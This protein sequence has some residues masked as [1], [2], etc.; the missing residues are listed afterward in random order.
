MVR[1]V[2]L[3]DKATIHFIGAW[4][5]PLVQKLAL[6]QVRTGSTSDSSA[7]ES[8]PSLASFKF[9]ANLT[10]NVREQVNW[11]PCTHSWRVSMKRGA[12]TEDN[13][14]TTA[15]YP[16]LK[17]SEYEAGNISAY[18]RAVEKWNEWNDLQKSKRQRI[19]TAFARTLE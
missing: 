14:Q 6:R 19:G 8:A 16:S 10:P 2:L 12:N 5:V 1:P 3:L 11:N 17:A 4:I 15:V 9:T 18:K 13:S 7:T